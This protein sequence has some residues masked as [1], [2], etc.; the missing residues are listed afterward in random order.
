MTDLVDYWL[1]FRIEA[2]TVGGVTS[3]QRR[4]A[5]YAAISGVSS[6]WWIEPT[7]F[8]FFDSTQSMS[9]IAAKCKAAI[10]P[11]HDLVVIRKLNVQDARVIGKVENLELLKA[12]MPY[13][14]TV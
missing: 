8:I 10:S 5:L 9:T 11:K 12:F 14:S 1:T 13:L 7:S 6:A 2:V 3:A 4:E